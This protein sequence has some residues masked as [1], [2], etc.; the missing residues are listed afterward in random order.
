LSMP[1]DVRREQAVRLRDL[2][3]VHT[4]ASWLQAQISAACA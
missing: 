2:A 4:P 3:S 1:A